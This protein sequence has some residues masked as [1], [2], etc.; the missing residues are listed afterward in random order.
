MIP[1]GVE[2]I[3]SQAF[4]QC[5]SLY[6]LSLPETV[7]YVGQNNFNGD[8]ALLSLTVYNPDCHLMT[9]DYELPKQVLLYCYQ[10]SSLYWYAQQ[11]GREYV[12][13]DTPETTTPS[14]TTAPPETTATSPVTSTAAVSTATESVT[15]AQTTTTTA[16]TAETTAQTTET[17]AVSTATETAPVAETGDVD[18]DGAVSLDDAF[19]ILQAY[20]RVSA[21]A[22]S[23]LEDWQLLRADV[24][25]S[26]SVDLDDAFYI[27]QY[28][29]LRSAGREVGSLDDWLSQILA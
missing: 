14:V 20:A 26:G 11:Y 15:T 27:L 1:S 2:R 23:G 6:A 22:E 25:G 28:D 3:E 24:D 8:T 29:S 5:S 10:D 12:L 9:S 7:S 19:L 13:L 4:V 21:G 18:G 16:T 17:A